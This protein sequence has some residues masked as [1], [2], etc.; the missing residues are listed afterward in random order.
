MAE[1]LRVKAELK[2]KAAKPM[3]YKESMSQEKNKQK[4]LQKSKQEKREAMCEELGRGCWYAW[5]LIGQRQTNLMN[6]TSRVMINQPNFFTCKDLAITLSNDIVH[7]VVGLII[8]VC[9]IWRYDI[10]CC[11]RLQ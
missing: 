6:H 3:G 10:I 1:R 11:I 9:C 7:Y 5:S 8:N 4:E 2:K